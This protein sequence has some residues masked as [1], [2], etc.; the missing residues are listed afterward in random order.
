MDRIVRAFSPEALRD[1]VTIAESALVTGPN[2]DALVAAD[3]AGLSRLP[4]TVGVAATAKA[5]AWAAAAWIPVGRVAESP[6]AATYAASEQTGP[7]GDRPYRLV[8]YRSSR[9]DRRKAK[10]L[11]RELA[12]ARATAERAADALAAQDFACAADA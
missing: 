2:L 3:L 7:M 6:Q 11:E 4:D 1:L 5:A 9:R 8:G 10:P 12:Q